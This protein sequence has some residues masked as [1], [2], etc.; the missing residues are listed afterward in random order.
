MDT[1]IMTIRTV[2]SLIYEKCLSIE[3]NE[4]SAAPSDT[5]LAVRTVQTLRVFKGK[6]NAK[7]FSMLI[8][9]IKAEE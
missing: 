4:I 6:Y 5:L 8:I 3:N 9:T 7:N 2:L 1:E